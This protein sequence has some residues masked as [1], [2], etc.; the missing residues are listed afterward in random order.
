MKEL[1][2]ET[3]TLPVGEVDFLLA[4]AE[5]DDHAASIRKDDLFEPLAMCTPPPPPPPPPPL[6][7]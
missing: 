1:R 6:E 4:L 3:G 7:C 5:L 2:G